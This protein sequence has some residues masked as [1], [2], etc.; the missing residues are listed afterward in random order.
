MKRSVDI[1]EVTSLVRTYVLYPTLDCSFNMEEG[2][3]RR[4]W[5]RLK[6]WVVTN[7]VRTS[8]LHMSIPQAFSFNMDVDGLKRKRIPV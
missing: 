3:L 7:I 2:G 4:K 6:D 5:R 1:W 8:L